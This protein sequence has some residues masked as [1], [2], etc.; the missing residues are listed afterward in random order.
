MV[1]RE[2]TK[3]IDAVQLL[4]ARGDVKIP[5]IEFIKE[6][7]NLAA[8]VKLDFSATLTDKDGDTATDLFSADLY[9][10][11]IAGLFDFVLAGAAAEQDAFNIDLQTEKDAYQ[12]SGFDTGTDKLVLIGDA[13]AVVT[14]I[15]NS[16]ADSIV[17]ITETGAQVT[18]VTVVG[19][20]L[21]GSHVAFG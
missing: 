17:T 16:G 18:T 1:E 21:L 5:V 13:T 15:D 19:V 8:D 20:D 10:N 14:N 7:E 12:V 4:M 9:A 6:V 2:G 11:E 3:L